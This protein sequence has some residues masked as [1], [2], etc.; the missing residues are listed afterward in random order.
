MADNNTG[1]LA[2]I[3][4][5]LLSNPALVQTALS[6]LSHGS[7]SSG[8][9][10]GGLDMSSLLNLF[11]GSGGTSA[12]VTEAPDIRT[13]GKPFDLE[14]FLASLPKTDASQSRPK[15]A[16]EPYE[17]EDSLTAK[18]SPAD[19]ESSAVFLPTMQRKD[20]RHHGSLR[21]DTALLLALR[22]YLNAERRAMIDN[23][24]RVGR[25]MDSFRHF[26]TKDG[27]L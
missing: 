5:T 8:S 10:L 24:V 14:A 6:L 17:K 13:N 2:G 4:G 27:S 7:G 1:P 23:I 21:S 9:S 26:N 25:L 3:V 15:E 12:P 11:G 18:E 22:P 16:T 20:E 19:T